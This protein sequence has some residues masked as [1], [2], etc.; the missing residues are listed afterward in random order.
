MPI[1]KAPENF[2]GRLHRAINSRGQQVPYML[3]SLPMVP[4]HEDFDARLTQAIRERRRRVAPPLDGVSA[5][6]L[7]RG[8][9]LSGAVI[10][11]GL[12]LGF[13]HIGEFGTPFVAGTPA[14][15]VEQ[16]GGTSSSTVQPAERNR[17]ASIASVPHTVASNGKVSS[18]VLQK[19]SSLANVSVGSAVDQQDHRSTDSRGSEPART[20]DLPSRPANR[21]RA[22]SA[23]ALAVGVNGYLPT[24]I[25]I[26]SSLPSTYTHRVLQPAQFQPEPAATGS[27]FR[28]ED[29]TAPRKQDSRG[30]TLP[31]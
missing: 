17:A 3:G 18:Q 30:S 8:R 19:E 7:V 1:V 28:D 16:M 25:E 24:P 9:W 29:E 26:P 13:L 10:V 5:G 27:D 11:G 21:L 15:V 14:P 20:R 22:Q 23:D 2:E 12:L 4:A 6:A 31:R